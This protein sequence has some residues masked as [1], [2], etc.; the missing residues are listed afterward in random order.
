[1]A[2]ASA[3]LFCK[4]GSGLWGN[5]RRERKSFRAANHARAAAT[6]RYSSPKC[7]PLADSAE[8]ATNKKDQEF[9]ARATSAAYRSR[10]REYV[11]HH[12]RLRAWRITELRAS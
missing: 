6:R 3:P 4:T 1:M 12:R 8:L 11:G 9:S 10:G 5:D 2:P 7:P